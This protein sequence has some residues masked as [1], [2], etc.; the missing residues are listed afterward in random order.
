[1]ALQSYFPNTE[2]DRIV[3][4]GNY[5][6]KIATHGAAV[7]LNT[8][9][10]SDIQADIAYYLWLLQS[11]NPA[12]QQYAQAATAYKNQIAT[13]EGS[14]P[15]PAIT[16]IT[17]QPPARPAGVLTRLF[18]QIARFKTHAGYTETIGR[19]LGV[20]AT[21]SNT[22]R[23]YPDFTAAP[24]TGATHQVVRINFTKYGHD[25][26]WIES[27][28]GGGNWEFLAIDTVKPYIDDRPLLTPGT[29]ETREYRLRWW[30]KGE[31]NGDW[32]PV[33]S[34]AVGA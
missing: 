19:D 16:A 32:T 12:V 30:D 26:V 10:I 28:R 27:R 13:G 20:I 33:Q 7:G 6:A 17:A 22:D 9:E 2:A 23:P 18:A 14:P 25:G 24:E 1:M 31:A 3:W 15:L 34:L 29:A 11:W 5:R 21:A 4:L 8:T